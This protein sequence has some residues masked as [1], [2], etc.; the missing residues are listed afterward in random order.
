MKQHSNAN[1]GSSGWKPEG[2]ASRF[3]KPSYSRCFSVFEHQTLSV[4]DTQNGVTFTA[5]HFQN[6]FRFYQKKSTKFFKPTH[7][8]IK[9]SHYVGALQTGDLTI[10][11]LP[12]AD[13]KKPPDSTLWQ[14]VLLDLLREC[15]LIKMEGLTHAA[16]RLRPNAILDLYVEIFLTEV[17]RLL[18]EGL[19]KSYQRQEANLPI[20]KGRLVVPK[21]IRKNQVQK[22]RFYVNFEKYDY[23]HFCLLYTSP[24]PRDS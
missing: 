22:D 6:L 16:L 11:I 5:A 1:R 13:A 3:T 10:E 15:K 18:Q 14:S 7:N 24:S 20:L 8:G 4:G 17:E 21:H 9:F 19:V 2:Q 23:N 12:K